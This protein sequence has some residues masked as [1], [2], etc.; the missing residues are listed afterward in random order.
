MNIAMG[1]SRN[2][3]VSL[4]KIRFQ[5]WHGRAPL[6]CSAVLCRLYSRKGVP[7]AE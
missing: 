1:R 2:R 5:I 4:L 3:G 7:N 6:I